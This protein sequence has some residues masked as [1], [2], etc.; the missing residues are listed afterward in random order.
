MHELHRQG[1]VLPQGTRASL[2]RT[3]VMQPIFSYLYHTRATGSNRP[4]SY[5]CT[6][7]K[8]ALLWALRARMGQGRTSAPHRLGRLCPGT[9]TVTM[10]ISCD[11]AQQLV[12]Q[13]YCGKSARSPIS[14]GRQ[15]RDA[16][17]LV[18]PLLAKAAELS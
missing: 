2:G 5:L 3:R 13:W 11:S 15:I 6:G 18:A 9:L 14:T 4:Q 17:L 16:H 1:E 10:C 8:Q 12:A 7:C